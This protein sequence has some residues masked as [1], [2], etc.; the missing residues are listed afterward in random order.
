[1]PRVLTMHRATVPVGDRR[2]YLARLRMRRDHY[3]SNGCNFWAFEEAGLQ[4][5]FI[6]FTEASDERTLKA[7]HAAL[8]TRA[9]DVA[10]IY[11]EVEF[12]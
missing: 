6:E 8:P 11:R 7:A 2:E 10:R 5:A 12:G 9:G 3:T 1:M 4:G